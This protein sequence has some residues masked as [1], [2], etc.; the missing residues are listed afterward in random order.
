LGLD[1]FLEEGV[2]I[3]RG[4]TEVLVE[5]VLDIIPENENLEICD[6]CCGSGAIG[7]AFAHH[8][9]NISVDCIDFYDVPEKITKKNII[10]NQLEGRVNYIKSDLLEVPIY[11]E[12]KYNVI[13][14]NPPYI[15]EEEIDKLMIDVRDYEPRTALSGG[16]DG[17]LF[18]RKIVEDSKKILL[19]DGILSFEIGYDQGEA[20]KNLMEGNGYEE[21]KVIKDLAGLDRVVMGKFSY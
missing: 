21:I 16:E 13:V 4:D 18:Y 14:S 12:K 1:F 17:L 7:I 6:L 2:L 5:Q 20:V 15:K 3:P 11:E 8:R 10:R 9:K 19:K